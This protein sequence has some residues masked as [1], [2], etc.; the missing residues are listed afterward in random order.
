MWCND[1]GRTFYSLD[2]VRKHMRDKGHCRMLHEGIALAE[3]AD[4]YDYSSSYPD[5]VSRQMFN[6]HFYHNQALKTY[7][8]WK[9]ETFLEI[10]L[11]YSQT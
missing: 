5:H 1:R 3:Y 8:R 7:R 2:A 10:Q 6:F 4:F 11:E 9:F